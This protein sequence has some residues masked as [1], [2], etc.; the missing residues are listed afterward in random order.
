MITTPVSYQ[1]G[2]S[3]LA[4]YPCQSCHQLYNSAQGPSLHPMA[5]KYGSDPHAR[6]D[7][8]ISVLNGREGAWGRPPMSGYQGHATGSLLRKDGIAGP[9]YGMAREVRAVS[10]LLK[11]ALRST[12]RVSIR[13]PAAP[14]PG[15]PAK[16][17]Q[18]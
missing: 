2:E 6:E 10:S 13:R 4:K 16:M 3:L 11:L 14:M 12:C 5:D 8:A 9:G 15:G 18:I 1:T 17:A 7:L